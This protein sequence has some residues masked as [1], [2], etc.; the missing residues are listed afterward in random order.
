MGQLMN[1]INGT[2]ERC[3]KENIGISKN[4]IRNLVKSNTISYV[5]VG[6]NQVLINFEVLKEYLST[7]TT[8]PS[9]VKGEINT[10]SEKIH[11]HNNEV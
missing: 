8:Q 7:G 11:V 9:K 4:L 5:Q 3:K 10:I 2:F 1:T 6:N